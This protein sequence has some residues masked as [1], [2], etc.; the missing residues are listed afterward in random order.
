MFRDFWR[1][2]VY[3][4]NL[5][6]QKSARTEAPRLLAQ[7]LRRRGSVWQAIRTSFVSNLWRY[8]V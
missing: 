1:V 4:N 6:Q 8:N 2:W 7:S 3:R 5:E